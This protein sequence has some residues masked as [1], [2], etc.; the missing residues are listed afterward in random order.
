MVF[1]LECSEICTYYLTTFQNLGTKPRQH[2][3]T[4]VRQVVFDLVFLIENVLLLLYAMNAVNTP[5]EIVESKSEFGGVLLGFIFLGLI[6]K[7]VYYQYIHIWAWLILTNDYKT[8][9]KDGHWM[10]YTKSNMFFCGKIF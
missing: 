6:L 9:S 8:D 4:L 5:L 10:C 2:V 1:T 7:W 3:S